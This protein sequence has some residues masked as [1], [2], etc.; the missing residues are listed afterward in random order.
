[1]NL[2]NEVRCVAYEAAGGG[3]SGGDSGGGGS[4]GGDATAVPAKPLTTTEGPPSA[5]FCTAPSIA[6]LADLKALARNSSWVFMGDSTTR[7]LVGGFAAEM[8]GWASLEQNKAARDFW[9]A[10]VIGAT[11]SQLEQSAKDLSHLENVY[12][13]IPKQIDS[14]L[15]KALNEAVVHPPPNPSHSTVSPTILARTWLDKGR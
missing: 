12:S 1:M 15:K 11:Q 2:F 5:C 14:K 3:G 4:G 13:S 6:T 8:I 9:T 10:S 7:N